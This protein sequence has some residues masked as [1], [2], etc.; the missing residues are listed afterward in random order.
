MIDKEKFIEYLDK[1]T[2]DRVIDD[3]QNCLDEWSLKEL[4][5]RSAIVTLTRFAVDL[6]F[7]FS[8]TQAEALQLI[9]SMVHDH[10]EIPDFEDQAN[11]EPE[12]II[13]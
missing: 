13:H 12:K 7:K 1:Q 11:E 2:C 3:V 4:D 10:M 5:S 6:A 9:L 8:H